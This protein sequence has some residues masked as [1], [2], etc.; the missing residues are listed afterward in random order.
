MDQCRREISKSLSAL[1]RKRVRLVIASTISTQ[2]LP[3]IVRVRVRRQT[4]FAP[5]HFN[6]GGTCVNVSMVRASTRPWPLSCDVAVRKSSCRAT[7]SAGGKRRV[8]RVEDGLFQAWLVIL[9]G[10]EIIASTVNHLL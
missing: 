4:C 6:Q 10:E 3:L 5:G 1:A 9:D 2:V 8:E 7:F